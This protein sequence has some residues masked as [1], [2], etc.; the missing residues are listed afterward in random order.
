MPINLPD[1]QPFG[2][3]QFNN[4]ITISDGT[5]DT[6]PNVL[7]K[8]NQNINKTSTHLREKLFA[9]RSYYVSNLGNVNNTGLTSLDPLP[10]INLVNKI[11]YNNLDLNGYTVTIN[12]A[13]GTYNDYIVFD[14]T[15][16]GSSNTEYPIVIEGNVSNPDAVVWVYSNNV[17]ACCVNLK[18]QTRLLIKNLSFTNSNNVAINLSA[19]LCRDSILSLSNIYFNSF[20]VNNQLINLNN[21]TLYYNTIKIRGT[22]GF[23]IKADKSTILSNGSN[24]SWLFEAAVVTALIKLSNV[25]V[26]ILTNITYVGT[27]TGYKYQKDFTSNIIA[28]TFPTGLTSSIEDATV[29]NSALTVNN[30]VNIS[31]LLTVQDNVLL[32][33]NLTVSLNSNV[34]GNLSITGS[35]T[36]TGPT[37]TGDLNLLG[38]LTSNISSISTFNG[39]VNVNNLAT[40]FNTVFKDDVT[41]ETKATFYQDLIALGSVLLPNGVIT[42]SNLSASTSTGTVGN[43]GDVL[44]SNTTVANGLSWSPRLTNVENNLTLKANLISP[45]FTGVPTVPTPARTSNTS[46]I[47]NTAY[48]NDLIHFTVNQIMTWVQQRVP[49]KLIMAWSGN[50]EDIKAPYFICDG[51]NGT[52]DLR[53]KF[54][55]GAG[56]QTG[57]AFCI[58]ETG[59]SS[60]ITFNT[61][62]ITSEAVKVNINI[63]SEGVALT[64]DQ[65]P[66]HNH[67]NNLTMVYYGGDTLGITS[68]AGGGKGGSTGTTV[69]F[70]TPVNETSVGLSQPHAHNIFGQTESHT[71][72]VNLPANTYSTL[73]PYH[74]LAYV[75]LSPTT[76]TFNIT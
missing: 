66:S 75:L 1:I 38:N 29:F 53:N 11:I 48:V 26:C 16:L 39:V 43:L 19:I 20:G 67:F 65:I 15:P 56:K 41:F 2:F 30:S 4:G 21:S 69:G 71:H 49:E 52:P 46:Q 62:T 17:N 3:K 45:T 13:D 8:L 22:N 57:T 24:C 37:T 18:N 47:A 44:V 36:L 34:G 7:D 27:A 10:N 42:K 12:L 40:L 54:I 74:V 5:G 32:N 73:P 68:G 76:Y 72:T 55:M 35:S 60:T 9:N 25:S 6:L 59:G 33:K 14:G 70:I 50:V 51:N 23:Y 58:N 64:T 31:G 28:T 63:K 61:S